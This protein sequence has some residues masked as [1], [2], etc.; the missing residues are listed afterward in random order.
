MTEVNKIPARRNRIELDPF[1][2][3]CG[4]YKG[5]GSCTRVDCSAVLPDYE[6][7]KDRQHRQV[8]CL[9]SDQLVWFCSQ[10]KKGYCNAHSLGYQESI[11]R[12]FYQHLG[13]C[14]L[15]GEFVCE[16]CWV[17]DEIGRIRCINHQVDA[18]KK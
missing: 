16:N 12:Y 18:L 11:L 7:N 1:C 15:C 5:I 10:C 14:H 4:R 6:E 13:T 8:C 2:D 9:C 3:K 17:L